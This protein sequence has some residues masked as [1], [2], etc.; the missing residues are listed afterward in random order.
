[1]LAVDMSTA[2]LTMAENGE[3]QRIHDLW[4]SSSPCNAETNQVE[5]NQLNLDSFWGLFLITGATS[6]GSLTI[7]MLMLLLRFCREGSHTDSSPVESWSS[8]GVG[9]IRSFASYVDEPSKRPK[10]DEKKKKKKK[11]NN[12]KAD[13]TTAQLS[14]DSSSTSSDDSHH[15]PNKSF[16]IHGNGSIVNNNTSF[17]L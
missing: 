11:K 16:D 6:F 14:G 1:M 7:Y 2:I 8:R 10:S 15:V 3:L 5:S 9:L 4:L 12:N 13:Q 17:A